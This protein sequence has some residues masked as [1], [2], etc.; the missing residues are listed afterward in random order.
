VSDKGPFDDRYAGSITVAFW[1]FLLTITML[2]AFV[3]CQAQID[4]IEKALKLQ[5]CEF[6]MR[7][8]ACK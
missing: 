4:R 1:L 6:S 7:T 8:L 3:V 2:G 5:P